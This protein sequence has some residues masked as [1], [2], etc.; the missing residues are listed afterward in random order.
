MKEEERR[1]NEIQRNVQTEHFQHNIKSIVAISR[2]CP[3]QVEWPMSVSPSPSST[4]SVTTDETLQDA[5]DERRV[6]A[7]EN[8]G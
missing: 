4:L 8:I 7:P 2:I 1:W 3:E 5:R 6:A